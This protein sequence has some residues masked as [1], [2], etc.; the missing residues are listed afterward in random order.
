[1][2]H[3]G[4]TGT[5]RARVF[6]D[7]RISCGFTAVCGMC[8][9][10]CTIKIKNNGPNPLSR[11]LKVVPNVLFGISPKRCQSAKTRVV[12]II[13]NNHHNPCQLDTH[14]IENQKLCL[15]TLLQLP[16][17]YATGV[18]RGPKP[19]QKIFLEEKAFV[20]KSD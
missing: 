10:T 16:S 3:M 14:L 18:T 6:S 20:S 2:I 12:P 15:I 1:M 5:P 8:V 13:K 11:S 17:L 19:R 9:C 7:S 4:R